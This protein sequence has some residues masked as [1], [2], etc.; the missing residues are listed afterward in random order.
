MTIHD[1][2][3]MKKEGKK[4]AVLTAYD[5]PFARIL[6]EAGVD[7]IM[8]G[9]SLGN[10]V[11]GYPHTLPVTMEEML[12]HAKAVGRAVKNALLVGDMPFGSYQESVDQCIKNAVRFVKEAGVQAVKLEGGT[13]MAER[14]RALVEIGI[15]VMGHVGLTPQS[16]HQMGGYKVQGKDRKDAARILKDAQALE[17]A[18]AF[19]VVL[20]G[21]P[22]SLAKTITARLSIPTI[23]IGAGPHCDGQVLVMHDLLGLSGDFKPRF[24]RCYARLGESAFRAVQEFTRDVREGKFPSPG[25]SYGKED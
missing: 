1:I 20:E 17:K 4:I 9:D 19:S 25:E 16:V 21:I 8:V 7:I 24:A 18:G 23:G 5:F 3:K 15:P 11:L 14:A 13:L 12:H 22:L 10:A 6:D 2:L